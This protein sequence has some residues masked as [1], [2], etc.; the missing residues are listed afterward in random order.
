MDYLRCTCR[1]ER[2]QPVVTA[3]ALFFSGVTKVGVTRAATDGVASYFFLKK[4]A[5]F[6]VIVL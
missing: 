5:T 2:R 3:D 6:L 1:L 4:V